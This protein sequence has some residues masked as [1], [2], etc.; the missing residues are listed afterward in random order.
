[1]TFKKQEYLNSACKDV[2]NPPRS[3]TTNVVMCGGFIT[4][5]CY[6]ND[7]RCEMK[8]VTGGV[9]EGGKERGI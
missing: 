2:I 4:A 3:L 9:M 7:P 1:M 6:K 5:Y 8:T